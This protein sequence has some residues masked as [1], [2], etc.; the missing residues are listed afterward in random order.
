MLG[1]RDLFAHATKDEAT[2]HGRGILEFRK[3]IE[4]DMGIGGIVGGETISPGSAELS[5]L[6]GKADKEKKKL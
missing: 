5:A 1:G 2:N 4:G 3:L 6:V